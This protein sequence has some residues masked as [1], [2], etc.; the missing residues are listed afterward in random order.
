MRRTLIAL[1]A[2]AILLP[3]CE[4]EIVV[5]LPDA[6]MRYVVEGT[7]SPNSPPLII[8]T[9]TQS[10][11]D[12]LDIN[13]IA[14]IFVSGATVTVD[15]GSGPIA[16]DQ[17]CS[18]S[19][20]A[21]QIAQAAELT[22]LSADLLAAADICIYTKLD[23]S[24]LGQIGTTYALRIEV[25][26]ETLTSTTTIPNPVPL[27]SLWFRLAQQQPNDDSLGFIWARFTDPDTIGNYYRWAHRR[28]NLGSDGEPKD[29]TF[30]PASFSTFEDR[31][32]NGL[33][34]DFNQNRT[35]APFSSALD[36]ENE[37]AGYFKR[38]DTVV[39]RFSSLGRREY[40]FY[41]SMDLNVN[42]QGDLFS[43]PANVKS[44]ISGGLGVWAGVANYV[45]TV[46]CVP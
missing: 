40:D 27:D 13:A 12:P 14:G 18:G 5:E 20:T 34:F 37:E 35:A 1:L 44:N 11:F 24:L 16:L 15:A 30:I 33:T 26:G 28:I 4:K 9:K 21:E 29:A 43:N 10:W 23:L 8:L 36:D 7:I 45:D 3:S 2:L 17:I 22:G 41:T 31:F 42:S 46:V 38:N 19:L 39:I 25:G 6:P 32:I